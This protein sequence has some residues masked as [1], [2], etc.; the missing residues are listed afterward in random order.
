[1]NN[2]YELY[3]FGHDDCEPTGI[4]IFAENRLFAYYQARWCYPA[5][6]KNAMELIEV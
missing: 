1:M 6:D 3:V 2:K 4:Y 5:L